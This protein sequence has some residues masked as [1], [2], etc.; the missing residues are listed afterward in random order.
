MSS[1][2]PAVVDKFLAAG[3]F[4]YFVSKEGHSKLARRAQPTEVENPNFKLH[5]FSFLNW[6]G[7]VTNRPL[8]KKVDSSK[9]KLEKKQ[10]GKQQS[11]KG[12]KRQKKEK[13]DKPGWMFEE[14]S[15]DKLKEPR[16]W[17]GTQWYW[18]SKKTGGKCSG[19]YRAHKPSQCKGTESKKGISSSSSGGSLLSTFCGMKSKNEKRAQDFLGVNGETC[20]ILITDHFSQMKHG[21]TRAGLLE[22][23]DVPSDA[24]SSLSIA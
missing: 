19:Q 14:P 2:F 15:A 3:S 4:E 1:F 6:R 24:H 16:S 23:E 9:R 7:D 22:S 10:G 18:C 5:N 20:W 8:R 12:P 13:K 11:E 21:A 17:N